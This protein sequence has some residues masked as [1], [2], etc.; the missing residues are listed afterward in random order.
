VVEGIDT[1]VLRRYLESVIGEVA[2]SSTHATLGSACEVLGLTQPPGEGTKYDRV[3][4]NLAGLPDAELPRVARLILTGVVMDARTRN[5]IQDLLWAGDDPPPIPKKARRE[6]SRAVDLDDL[7]RGGDRF[8]NLLDRLWVLD[9]DPLA[10]YSTARPDYALGSTD[11]S[12]ATQETGPPTSSSRTSA[13]STHPT[14]G[15]LCSWRG[16]RRRTSSSTSRPS[17]GSWT[18]STL[19]YAPPASSYA[20]PTLTVATR[21]SPSY[22]CRPGP[23]AARR[24]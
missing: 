13:P 22:R 11:T 6:I 23:I 21:C 8:R 18:R 16:W 15:S 5:A 4:H 1:T 24:T 2:R 19:T 17:E 14:E 9:T 10:T 20:K 12:S 7:V 3:S